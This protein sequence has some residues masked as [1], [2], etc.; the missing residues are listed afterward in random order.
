MVSDDDVKMLMKTL[1]ITDVKEPHFFV[2]DAEGKIIYHTQGEY[3]DQ[4][5]NE[6]TERLL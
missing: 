4:K 6:I 1:G 2:L 5:L 3:S